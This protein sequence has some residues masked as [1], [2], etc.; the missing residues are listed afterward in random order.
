MQEAGPG[1][2]FINPP[3]RDHVSWAGEIQERALHAKELRHPSANG[4]QRPQANHQNTTDTNTP[5]SAPQALHIFTRLTFSS[6]PR[7]ID[8]QA[9]IVYT[10]TRL[11]QVDGSQ[12]LN[13]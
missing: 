2:G 13:R 9:V 6:L 1:P 4:L 12:I 10:L 8:F 3:R 11:V 5:E 7:R